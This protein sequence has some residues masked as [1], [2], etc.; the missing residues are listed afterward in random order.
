[1]IQERL[2]WEQNS[3]YLFLGE[4]VKEQFDYNTWY[5]GNTEYALEQLN[6]NVC[7]TYTSIDIPIDKTWGDTFYQRW[8]CL[9]TYPFSEQEVNS[10]VE[11]LSFMLESH[12][13]LDGRSDVNRGT[14]NLVN[15]RPSNTNIFNTSYNQ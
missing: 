2:D 7:S 11:I 8:E 4:L 6:W 12:M 13:N 3:L 15:N 1:M 10:N 5:G 9:K 14:Y